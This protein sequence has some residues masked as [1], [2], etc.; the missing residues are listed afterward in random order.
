MKLTNQK[1]LKTASAFML[2]ACIIITGVRVP[3]AAADIVTSTQLAEQTQISEQRDRVNSLLAR[4]DVMAQLSQLGVNPTDLKQ[5][6]DVLTD[7]EVRELQQRIDEL[8]AGG[9]I[10]G[11]AIGLIVIFLL[12]DM[13]GAT[14]VF[15]DV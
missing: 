12:L 7:Q 15:P 6:V 1:R 9:S 5:R 10:L 4:T 8:P 3:M 2:V 11:V 14:D 13:A